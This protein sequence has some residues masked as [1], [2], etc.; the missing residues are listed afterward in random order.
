M[1]GPSGRA[2]S[3]GVRLAPSG[4]F[5]AATVSAGASEAGAPSSALADSVCAETA[6]TQS[7]AANAAPAATA[8]ACVNFIPRLP[9]GSPGEPVSP[10][11]QQTDR[12]PA[13]RTT[14]S[15][16]CFCLRSGPGAGFARHHIGA[17]RTSAKTVHAVL[18][19]LHQTSPESRSSC[20]MTRPA[21]APRLF[22]MEGGCNL[23]EEFRSW[24]PVASGVVEGRSDR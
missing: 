21:A 2:P 5:G 24:R 1:G 11:S 15:K 12:R 7:D 6:P 16:L 14:R 19:M 4:A 17:Y 18:C 9:S 10:E 8:T 13:N 20:T 22:R 23:P 3:G